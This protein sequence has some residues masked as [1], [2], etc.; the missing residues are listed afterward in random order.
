MKTRR[1]PQ[2]PLDPP[3]EYFEPM[4]TIVLRW[5]RLEYQ[6]SVVLRLLVRASKK[7]QYQGLLSK[8]TRDLCALLT[9]V[10]PTMTDTGTAARLVALAKEVRKRE[11][12]R[13]DF[14]HSVYGNWNDVPT[15]PTR[16]RL[17]NN[18]LGLIQGYP[19]SSG[20]MQTFADVVRKLQEEA[21]AITTTIKSHVKQTGRP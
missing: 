13:D 3:A 19:V 16:F 18:E 21:Q 20:D 17:L 15:A 4:G 12:A 6:L 8:R 10:S 11:K 1:L 9:M 5:S 14:V 7:K 2:S